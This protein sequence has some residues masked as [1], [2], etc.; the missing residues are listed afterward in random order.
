VAEHA[1][2]LRLRCCVRG[3]WG[4]SRV[5][6]SWRR[7]SWGAASA[8]DVAAGGGGGDDETH[9]RRV[10]AS[11]WDGFARFGEQGF[12]LLAY[13]GFE[14]VLGCSPIRDLRGFWLCFSIYI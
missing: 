4:P 2:E 11:A 8:E 7:R 3:W 9:C 12:G 1:D 5:G 6:S 13:S 10:T 14:R